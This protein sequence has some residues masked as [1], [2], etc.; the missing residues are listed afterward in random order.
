ML[1]AFDNYIIELG[2]TM[3]ARAVVVSELQID[4]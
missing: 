1:M 4:F 3:S 2:N